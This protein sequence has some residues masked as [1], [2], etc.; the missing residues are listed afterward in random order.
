ML[1]SKRCERLCHKY[2]PFSSRK[3]ALKTHV[4]PVL[5]GMPSLNHCVTLHGGGAD[6]CCIAHCVHPPS[7]W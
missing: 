2:M 3:T 1:T 6:C 5:P 4:L 7:G